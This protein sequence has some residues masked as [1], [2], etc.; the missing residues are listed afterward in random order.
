MTKAAEVGGNM[1]NKQRILRMVARWPEDISFGEA[2]YRVYALQKIE[3][4]LKS[5]E[6]APTI[7][8]DELFDEL[9]RLCDE[10]E[11]QAGVVVVGSRRSKTPSEL[12]RGGRVAAERVEVVAGGFEV[13]QRLVRVAFRREQHRLRQ[14]GIEAVVQRRFPHFLKRLFLGAV[15][16]RS[17][18]GI[19]RHHEQ[20][21]LIAASPGES[22]DRQPVRLGLTRALGIQYAAENIRVNAIAPGYVETPIAVDYWNTF[23]D[24]AAERRRA[25]DL[26]P[27]K[28][29]GRPE[30]VAMTALFLASDEAPFINA[31]CIVI[32]GGRSVLYHE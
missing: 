16:E 12:D 22:P 13:A 10:E 26:H 8:H 11:A 25:Y 6:S 9:E 31:A 3:A 5:I 21:T 1:T 29:I 7:D 20:L 30:E 24:P 28:R 23:E 27:P 32:D 14:Q 4:G 18:P 17:D 15:V 2:L 19:E